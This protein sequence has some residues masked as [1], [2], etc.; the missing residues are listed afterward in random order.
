[1]N[2]SARPSAS[3]LGARIPKGQGQAGN[4]DVPGNDVDD[5][6]NL[7]CDP[8]RAEADDRDVGANVQIPGQSQILVRAANRHVV[9]SGRRENRIGP[10]KG[11]GFEDRGPH[12]ATAGAIC[13]GSVPGSRIDGVHVAVDVERGCRSP[14][15]GEKASQERQRSQPWIRFHEA[16]QNWQG[17]SRGS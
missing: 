14:R 15:T 8:R 4:G 2:R 6:A 7:T 1:V 11:V 9:E 12:R 13:A 17:T 3:E 16:S 10:R 5:T